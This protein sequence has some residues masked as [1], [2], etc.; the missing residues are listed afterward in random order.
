MTNPITT[1][2]DRIDT[3][4]HRHSSHQEKRV[5]MST[6]SL[7]TACA[8]LVRY[9]WRPW[10]AC[11]AMGL[12][13]ACGGGG[14]GGP[15]AGEPGTT[16]V[17]GITA[18]VYDLSNTLVTGGGV[19]VK[20][21]DGRT[22]VIDGS[23][24]IAG[25]VIEIE[26]H[27]VNQLCKVTVSGSQSTVSCSQTLINDTG[28]SSCF[29]DGVT[30]ECG[31]GGVAAA[32]MIS[33]SP[34]SAAGVSTGTL[35]LQD[36]AKGRDPESGRLQKIGCGSGGFDFSRIGSD[37]KVIADGGGC[38]DPSPA[39][40]NWVCT[41]DNVTGLMWLR[42]PAES[43]AFRA[44]IPPGVACGLSNWRSPTADELAS[45]I[46][47]GSANTAIDTKRFPDVKSAI[48]WTGSA[49]RLVTDSAYAVRFSLSNVPKDF[50]PGGSIELFPKVDLFPSLWV[51]DTTRDDWRRLR[52]GPSTERFVPDFAKGVISDRHSGLMWMLC[53][54]GREPTRSAVGP[55]SGTAID[56]TWDDA[57]GRALV[58][59]QRAAL[60]YTD[61]RLPNRAELVSLV[62]YAGERVMIN[63]DLLIDTQND[64]SDGATYWSSSG[65]LG[66]DGRVQVHTVEFKL[67]TTGI[68]PVSDGAG[69][70]NRARVRLVRSIP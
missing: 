29:K 67:G 21:A 55:C 12:L 2:V 69:A 49:S 56:A 48:Y 1:T 43:A 44:A 8:G 53:S 3:N 54:A 66:A 16:S 57:L 11:V 28:I 65:A 36:G 70:N 25:V 24:V 17:S 41:R 40:A 59:N 47:S 32:A 30:V 5:N 64:Q 14:G 4:A 27:P 60:G 10:L 62:N 52:I 20:L 23:R 34:L 26:K 22:D 13:S 15:G 45:L 68:L 51:S 9:S 37:G 58:A 19:R 63:S 61:W 50:V 31:S 6:Q 42:K 33:G 46:N 35:A 7:T 39:D 18:P 38:P